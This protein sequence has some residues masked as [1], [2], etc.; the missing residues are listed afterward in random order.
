[1]FVQVFILELEF[2]SEMRVTAT[3]I[4]MFIWTEKIKTD[5]F[6]QK[7]SWIGYLVW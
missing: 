1:M 7:T 3:H 5:I 6:C 2:K 4:N